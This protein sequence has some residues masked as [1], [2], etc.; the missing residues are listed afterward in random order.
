MTVDHL[1]M[2][3]AA[4]GKGMSEMGSLLRENTFRESLVKLRIKDKYR[5]TSLVCLVLTDCVTS[6]LTK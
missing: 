2:L 1:K 4:G 5:E 3:H 6:A